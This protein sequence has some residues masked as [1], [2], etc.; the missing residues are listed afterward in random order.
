MEADKIS[1]RDFTIFNGRN[2]YSHRPVMKMIVDIGKYGD[3]STNK[4]PGFNEK[5]LEYFPGLKKNFCGLGYEG[6]F[7]ER[8]NEGTYLAHVLEHVILEM[9]S[10]LGYDVKYGKTRT[11]EEPSLY[12]LICEFENETCGLECG[13]ASVF[14]LNC[15]LNGETVF[16]E[17]FLSYLDK[18]ARDSELG[19]STTAIVN[20]AKLRGIPVTRIGNGSLIR[21]GYG[22]HSRLIEATLTDA[23]SCISAD[24]S[25]NKQLT[26]FLLGENQIPVPFGKMVY[27]ELSALMAA[28]QIGL[29]VVIKPFNGNQGKGVHLNLKNDEEIK[30]A[31]KEAS[32]YSNGIIVEKY[33][34]GH[35][36]RILVVGNKVR[37][38]SERLPASVT[39][40]GVHSIRE[41]VEMVNRDPQRG[42][43][44][45]KPLTI[46]RIDE[47]ALNVL[48][49]N[50]MTPE[51]VPHDGQTIVLRE[52]ANLSTGGT[53]IDCTD[54]IHPDNAE[55][56][57]RAANAIGI[58][59]AGI[60]IVADNI[61]ESVLETGGA[62]VE[63]NAAPGI[64]MH[65][66]PGKG[67]PRN[68][69]GDIVG[70]LFKDEESTSF[71][72]VSVTG[73]NGKTTVA[74]LINHTLTLSGKTVGLTCTSGTYV[75][76]KLV[77]RGDNSG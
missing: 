44:H 69:A 74:R 5:L 26:K 53:A 52:N 22:K 47:T 60:D 21:L 61:G 34:R 54:R 25:C 6:G 66:F 31:Y 48:K 27:S 64:R 29:P 23:T 68:V 37:A 35:D 75:G 56:A 24:I 55:I 63:V 4:I 51:H 59:I 36:Y 71:P 2:I 15:L 77:C 50:K 72:I 13:K 58:D 43:K 65:L 32:K 62:V 67:E 9:Q 70:F 28:N 18:V 17:E 33:I 8:L 42:E 46:I 3:I 12:Y 20:E 39:G 30:A 16:I 7:L 14:I 40:D 45:E 19:P 73:T 10:M 49:K 76:G 41:L 11:I 1:I 57:V 38:V